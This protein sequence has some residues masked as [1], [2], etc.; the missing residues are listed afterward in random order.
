M[1]ILLEKPE[2]ENFIRE[3]VDNGQYPSPT[4]GVEAALSQLMG[5][6]FAP[7]EL[8][9]LIAEGEASLIREGPKSF[10]DVFGRLENM[11]AEARSRAAK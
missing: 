5:P 10:E 9:R 11:S 8:D 7:G 4:A 3:Q 1:N 6:K 2:I